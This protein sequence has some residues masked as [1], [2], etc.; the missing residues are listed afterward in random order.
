MIQKK[1][2]IVIWQ[3]GDQYVAKAL[4]NSVS[5]FGTSKQEALDRCKEALELYYDGEESATYQTIQGASLVDYTLS[6]A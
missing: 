5:S 2:H 1:F 6:Y 4:E 3:E